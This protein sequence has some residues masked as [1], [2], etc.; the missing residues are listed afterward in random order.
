MLVPSPTFLHT[1]IQSAFDS[2]E[3]ALFF[4][5]K[6]CKKEGKFNFRVEYTYDSKNRLTLTIAYDGKNN[7]VSETRSGYSKTYEYGGDNR[8]F[9]TVENGLE[10]VYQYDLNGNMI[11]R[12]DDEF[13]YDEDNRMVYSKVN[14][15]ETTYEIGLDGLRCSK[16]KEGLV[17]SYDLDENGQVITEEGTEIIWGDRA[18]ARKTGNTYYY[19]IYNGHGDVVMLVDSSGNTKNT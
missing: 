18:L 1:E 5:K 11:R 12:G 16:D 7:L 4:S 9:R 8:L 6:F 2:F 17:T 10:T 15:V 19:Y 14:G 13:A 3:S